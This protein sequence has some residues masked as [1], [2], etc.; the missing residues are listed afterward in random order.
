[1]FTLIVGVGWVGLAAWTSHQIRDALRRGLWLWPPPNPLVS[2]TP[3]P[4][5]I[6]PMPLPI[7]YPLALTFLLSLLYLG[8]VQ[9]AYCAPFYT[10]SVSNLS[11]TYLV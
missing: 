2:P 4:T 1:M 11:K 10:T 3:D 7:G 8:K 5:S 6:P 9:L